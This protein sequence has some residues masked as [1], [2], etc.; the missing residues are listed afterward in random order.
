MGAV[1]KSTLALVVGYHVA[2]LGIL[3]A[4]FGTL[5]DYTRFHP[6]IQNVWD[7][8]T[9]FPTLAQAWP[10]ALRE[11][12]FE[13][14]RTI[15]GLPMAEWSVHILPA[16]LLVVALAAL[17]LSIHGHLSRRQCNPAAA[18]LTVTGSTGTALASAALTWTACC[19]SPGWAVLLAMAGL[20]T[21]TALSLEP[22]GSAIAASGLALLGIGI[23][24]QLRANRT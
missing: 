11:P 24:V 22:Y 6:W 23:A 3:V 2:L 19:A 4:R 18:F 5:P 20:W 1:L 9:G 15:P 16:K 13:I 14:G 8:L 7:V 17:A 12:L 10:V 21:S